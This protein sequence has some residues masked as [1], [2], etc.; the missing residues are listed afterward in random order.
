MNSRKDLKKEIKKAFNSLYRDLVY[1]EAFS[2]EVNQNA[3]RILIDRAVLA[4]EELIK[5]VSTNE[6]KHVKGRVK[7]Y[8]AKLRKDCAE[9]I[10]ELSKEIAA[11]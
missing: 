9:K 1:Y 3:A 6:G 10:A 7:M 4:E 5:R 2:V 8:F 11:L